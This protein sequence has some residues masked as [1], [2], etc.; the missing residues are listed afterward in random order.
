MASER[1][2]IMIKPDG[3]QRGIVG[4]IISRFEQK[5][6]KLVAMKLDKPTEEHLAIHYADLSTRKFFPGLIAYMA[7]G[8]VCCMV[9]EG[10]NVVATGRVMLGAT[11]PADS[12][13]GTIRGDLCIHVSNNICHGSDSVDAANAEIALWFPECPI[14]YAHHSAPWLYEDVPATAEGAILGMGNP[15][16]DI[17]ADVPLALLE[18]Y[19]LKMGAAILAEDAH[20]SLYDKLVAEYS[21]Q[22]IAGGATQ[23]SC[24][25]A[26]WIAGSSARVTA[27]SFIGCVGADESTEKLRSAV[28]ADGVKAYYLTDAEQPTGRCAALINESERSLVADI[29]AANCYQASHLDEPAVAAAIEKARVFYSAGFFLTVSVPALQKIA[30]HAGANANKW[31]TMNLS[32]EFLVQFFKDQ[33]MTMLPHCDIIFGNETEAAAFAATHELADASVGAVAQHIANLPKAD[34]TRPRYCVITQGADATCCAVAGGAAPTLYP[35][36]PIAKAD[37]VDS[38]G[39]G[40]AFVGG[41]LSVLQRT[42]AVTPECF[43]VGHKAAGRVIQVSGTSLQGLSW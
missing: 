6:F 37:I 34:A 30:T 25:V 24:R 4:Q 3:V 20:K 18:E 10:M 1:T 22:Y 42:G 27:A 33:M 21:P 38:N 5:G 13:P 31:F 35:V 11:N 29:A 15:I 32:A 26:Q 14:D 17:S 43:E 28:R 9:W 23:N 41:F 36:T 16:M 19:G 2:Y 7:S 39:A 40:D 8:P 12:A